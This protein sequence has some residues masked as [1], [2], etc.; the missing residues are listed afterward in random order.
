[1]LTWIDARVTFET[2]VSRLTA[3]PELV[4]KA[5]PLYAHFHKYES[6]YGELSQIRKLE[7]RMAELF[8]E[9][10]QLSQFAA[11]YSAE[12]FD[13][14]Q[15]RPTVSPAVQR[16]PKSTVMQ[17]IEQVPSVQDSPRPIYNSSPR[18]PFVQ[19][20]NSP[21]RPFPEDFESELNRPRKLARGESP[22]KGAAGRRLNEAKNARG[23]PQWQPNAPVSL[24]FSISSP[25]A[26]SVFAE[27]NAN[28]DIGTVRCSTRYNIPFEHYSSGGP[29]HCYQVQP[30]GYGPTS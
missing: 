25:T 1:M 15:V 29:L 26:W 12:G 24:L 22:L 16:R 23:T 17:S 27:D 11:R 18:P 8:P 19:I 3:K 7:Q 5:K 13:P 28:P 30:R 14:T 20:T 21:K 2:A 4:A 9:D 10:P 6:Q